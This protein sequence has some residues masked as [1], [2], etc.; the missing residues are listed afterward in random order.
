MPEDLVA[1]GRAIVDANL[2]MVLGTADG[3][4]RPW[5]TPVY[6]AHSRY[7]EFLWVS[8]PGAR[9]S[10]NIEARGEVSIVIFDSTVPI[11]T[12]NG[13][14]MS[15]TAGELGEDER[16]RALEVYTHRSL[17]HGGREW[18]ADDVLAPSHLRLYR[19]TAVEQY[20]LDE[21]DDRLAVEL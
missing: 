5:A 21:N 7:S 17:S 10:R 19:A 20:V 16:A 6:F 8:E 18:T 2:Y 15:A 1:H 13:V 14:Y 3:D 11:S 9:H 12:G 4:G